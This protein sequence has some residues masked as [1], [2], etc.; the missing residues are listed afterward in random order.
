MNITELK[1]AVKE[2]SQNE[3]AEFAEWFNEFQEALWDKQ[4]EQ[5]MKAGKFDALIRQAEQA[6]SERKCK[7]I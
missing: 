4:I 1:T 5:D 3:L 6:F 7:E 2:L